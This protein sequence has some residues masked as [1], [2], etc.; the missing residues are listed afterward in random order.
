M[1]INKGVYNKPPS[2]HLT[3]HKYSL[4]YELPKFI[5]AFIIYQG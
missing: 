4:I 2:C 3:E 5:Y 1:K